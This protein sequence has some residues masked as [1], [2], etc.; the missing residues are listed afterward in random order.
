M[1][2]VKNAIAL[3]EQLIATPSASKHEEDTASLIEAWFHA[4]HVITKRL[5][6]NVIAEHRAVNPNAPVLLLNSHHDTVTPSDGWNT[7]PYVPTWEGDV[8]YGLGSNDAGAA[9]VTMATVFMHLRTMSDLQYHIVFAAT[10][11]EETSGT[12][13]MELLTREYF[14]NAEHGIA[15]PALAI[16]GEPTNMQLA[17][18]EKG[19]I[20]LDCLAHGV[21]GHAAREEGVNAI[22]KALADI[23]W[24]RTYTFDRISEALGYVKMTVT[25]IGAGTQHNVVPDACAFVVDVRTTDAYT[26]QEVLEIIAA[27]VA[28]AI[29]PRSIRLQPSSIGISHPIVQKGIAMGLTTYGSPTMSDQS[30][31]PNDVPSFKIGPGNS[32]RSHT[33]NEYITRTEIANGIAVLTELLERYVA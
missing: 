13:G 22:Y 31:L 15:V 18:A 28:S 1:D 29:K 4:R 6:N 5:G 2:S 3:L 16:V 23:E 14:G 11:E 25:Q 7:N 12:G 10:A 19:L 8:L 20:V 9:L 21:T 17:I 24:F 32:A 27:N 26:N 30:L 33:P